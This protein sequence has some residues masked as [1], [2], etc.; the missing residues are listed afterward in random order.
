MRILI[1]VQS[2]QTLSAP[3]GIGRYVDGLT[4]GLSRIKGVEVFAILDGRLEPSATE[5]TEKLSRVVPEKNIVRWYPVGNL[6]SWNC[7]GFDYFLSRQLYLEAVRRVAPDVF[8]VGSA[9]EPGQQFVLPPLGAIQKHAAVAVVWYDDI[10][11]SDP[12]FYLED[13]VHTKTYLNSFAAL[14]SADLFLCISDYSRS[15]I[16]ALKPYVNAK[17][18]YGASFYLPLAKGKRENFIF[19]CGGLDERKNVPFL[20]D[21]YGALPPAVREQHPLYICCRKG[22]FEAQNLEHY[23]Q[24]SPA[25]ET[26]R[27]VE[28]DN[29]EELAKFYAACWLFVFPS[30]SEGLG[31]SVIEAMS[32]HAPVLCSNA[33]S[34]KE[35]WDFQPGQFDPTKKE[36]LT[37]L[38]SRCAGDEA[39]YRALSGHSEERSGYFTWEK[40]ARRC[41]SVFES[42]GIR[43]GWGDSRPVRL[44][45]V[46]LNAT[47]RLN[48]ELALAVQNRI[49]LYVDISEH[50]CHP[51]R[52]TGI[53]RVTEA[54][55][56]NIQPLLEGKNVGV[57]FIA[58]EKDWGGYRVL[59]RRNGKWKPGVH[60]N[61]GRGD[62]YLSVDLVA[63]QQIEYQQT[64]QVWKNRGVRFFIYVYDIGFELYPEF[65][66]DS[67]TI[68]LLD[69]WL[70]LTLTLADAVISDSAQVSREIRA[71]AAEQSIDVSA[72]HFINHHLGGDFAAKPRSCPARRLHKPK[73]FIAVSTVEPRKGY[74]DLIGAFEAAIDAGADIE[75]TVVGRAGWKCKDLVERLRNGKYAGKRI[76]WEDN[77][78]DERLQQ[79]YAG[80]DGFASSSSSSSYE[81]FGLGVVEAAYFG[82][83]LLLRDIPVYREIAGDGAVYF[84]SESL[85]DI[86]LDLAGGKRDLISSA[87]V[88]VLSWWES[89]GHL[90]QQI[91]ELMRGDLANAAKDVDA[92]VPVRPTDELLWALQEQAEHPAGKKASTPQAGVSRG[93]ITV[94]C[95]H[96]AKDNLKYAVMRKMAL[97]K[98]KRRHYDRKWRLLR[99]M[100]SAMCVRPA[101]TAL[102]HPA[103][104]V[105]GIRYYLRLW[106]YA[107]MR[108]LSFK[109]E[110]RAH[111]D[112][113]WQVL[114]EARH[115]SASGF[116]GFGGGYYMISKGN[117]SCL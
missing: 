81:G 55:N 56:Q 92:S 85:A 117:K 9:F 51:E 67:N 31:L 113:K 8:L 19:Y 47:E 54:F 95:R 33:T 22:N 13:E 75:L 97:T 30:L 21:A 89:V 5:V 60:C 94:D 41:I 112:K 45:G 39:F 34:L 65:I 58:A 111:Y 59:H 69:R 66:A 28:A 57:V 3:R 6:C 110:T 46:G 2:L 14:D 20:V 27:L 114:R 63:C 52:H 80:A 18:V 115:V 24:Q 37:A 98:E 93:G 16:E 101:D 62:C 15:G 64:L 72:V 79:L 25:R 87:G 105:T 103:R 49:T 40:T 36:E 78:D 82:L 104:G 12:A 7:M 68:R 77:C 88:E 90:V 26:I 96:Y 17:T 91:L 71:W 61:P 83:P 116:D 35:V 74:A 1:D 108:K 23:V 11:L 42:L 44:D 99:Q 10:P 32:Y 86:L 106:K 73:K 53:Q 76:F 48:Y 50:W 70:R 102:P 84:T 4:E 38:I 100:H 107:L 29:D 109:R 43:R